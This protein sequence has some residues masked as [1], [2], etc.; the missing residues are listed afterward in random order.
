[1]ASHTTSMES[2]VASGATYFDYQPTS[3][4]VSPMKARKPNVHCLDAF[5]Q[6]TGPLLEYPANASLYAKRAL[7]PLPP[8]L[9]AV[10]ALHR[11]TSSDSLCSGQSSRPGTAMTNRQSCEKSLPPL[12]SLQRCPSI[13]SVTSKAGDAEQTPMPRSR[14]GR[15]IS[16]RGFLN[17]NS[18]ASA[19]ADDVP[20]LTSST[21]SV[22]TRD[23]RTDSIV[24]DY[25]LTHVTTNL[26]SA[27]GS[28][29]PSTLSLTQLRA[30]SKKVNAAPPP[31]PTRPA[32]GR[33][34]STSAGA[35]HRW[36]PFGRN[37][38]D[39]KED[40]PPMPATPPF[41]QELSFGQCYYFF[42]RNCNGYVLSN[43][44]NGDACENCARSGYLGS[45]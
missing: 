41:G 40:L 26:S 11:C 17:R 4:E 45:P 6:R 37:S 14:A 43:G 21:S 36:N 34:Y 7:P 2:A 19:S 9:A 27:P 44:V 15:S 16:F 24:G 3:R 35:G 5:H 33:K 18:A 20:S 29:R 13:E 1:M 38:E 25:G 39:Y 10:P 8:P 22:T 23:S 12:P 30:V 42:A 32:S 31:L 28:R